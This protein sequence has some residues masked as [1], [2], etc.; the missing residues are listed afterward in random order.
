MLVLAIHALTFTVGFPA[1][2]FTLLTLLI[3]IRCHR[4]HP[5]LTAADLLLL[6]LTTADLLVLLFL[7]F[8][9]AEEAAMMVW[10]FPKAL[11]PIANFCFYSS[12]YLSTLFI[13]ALSVER[14]FGVVFPHRYNRRRRLWRTMATSVILWV[15]ALSHCS[16]VF[17]AEHHREFG[18]NGSEADG[19][20][21]FGFNGIKTW[22][23]GTDDSNHVDPTVLKMS[24]PRSFGV[25]GFDL[26]GFGLTKPNGIDTDAPSSS[27][28]DIT[29]P[30]GSKIRGADIYSI[31][32]PKTDLNI[33]TLQ[34]SDCTNTNTPHIPTTT[35]WISQNVS[36]TQSHMGYHC[37]DDFSPTQLRFVLPL[38][39]VLFLVLFL[40]PFAITVFCYVCIIRALLTRPHIPLQKKYRTVGLA[41]ATMANFVICFGPYNLSH[42]VGFVQ[43]RSP[44]WRPYALLLTTLSPA[45][46]P[47]I[48]YFSSSAVRRAVSGVV[49]AVRGT[50]CGFWGWCGQRE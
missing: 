10:P 17:V 6:H 29:T 31:S 38:R 36:K 23:S 50:V 5:H 15:V 26:G 34:F 46:D 27:T 8:K 1:N 45:L 20:R 19:E 3:K 21:G 7:P 48:F 9:M 42:V 11:C 30:G 24:N 47:F 37:Y 18:V 28:A 32:S 43:Q 49:G 16:I 14:Y 35:P 39:L 2:A 44:T 13:A 40:L 33:S 41:V 12:I 25:S 4:P 22:G